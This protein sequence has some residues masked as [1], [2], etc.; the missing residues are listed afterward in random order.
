L[1]VEAN[2]QCQRLR[3]NINFDILDAGFGSKR[4]N[5]ALCAGR[6]AEARRT[7]F[8]DIFINACNNRYLTARFFLTGAGIVTGDSRCIYRRSS[9]GRVIGGGQTFVRP[10]F[11]ARSEQ[12][13]ERQQR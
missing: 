2:R 7:H 4:V 13:R 9:S 10:A 5:Y 12:C 8:Y 3:V 1:P 6:S 11:A